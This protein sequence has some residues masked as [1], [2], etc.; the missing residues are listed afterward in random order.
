MIVFEP[1]AAPSARAGEAE[2]GGRRL[3][4]RLLPY[5][6]EWWASRFDP[7]D[8]RIVLRKPDAPVQ[9][10][11][12]DPAPWRAAAARLPAGPVLI[13]PCPPAEAEEIWGAYR[14]AVDGAVASGRGV[15]LLD[16]SAGVLPEPAGGKAAVVLASWRPETSGCRFPALAAA[17]TAGLPG[18]ALFPLVPGWTAEPETIESLL[19]EAAGCG[20]SSAAALIPSADGESRRAIFEAR[21]RADPSTADAFFDRIHHGDWREGLS[22]RLDEIRAA[23]ARRGLA[24][25]P[26][27]PLGLRSA[28][29][30]GAAAARL[31]ERAELV[32]G[33][34]HRV[35]MLHAAVRWLDE[36]A[37]D[38]AAVAREGNFRKIFPF[39]PEVAAIAE[40]ALLGD[41]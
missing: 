25:L 10:G 37:R 39:G 26:P 21:T 40:A 30:N 35:A 2:V 24:W 31:E 19:E 9:A 22:A 3:A 8:R 23:A 6:G 12:A 38:L 36:S 11:P 27:R 29:G 16:P 7:A 17:A 4:G 18:A 1:A 41:A 13:G 32:D 14:A 33:D 5:G 28:P 20:A 15:Y 34:E